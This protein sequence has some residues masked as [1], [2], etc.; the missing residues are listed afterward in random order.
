[1]K[2][3]EIASRNYKRFCSLNGSNY[4]ASEFALETIL[5]IIDK[6]NLSHILELGLGIGSISDTV[7]KYSK[8]KKQPIEYLGTEKNDF[9]LGVLPN[10]V[11]DYDKIQIFS[12][13]KEIHDKKF[14]LII[15]DGSDDLL[16]S[17]EKY[18][19]KNALIFIEGGRAE[20]TKTVLDIF[21]KSLFVNVITLKKNPPYAHEGRSVDSYIGGG[22]LIFTNPTFKMKL[23][24]MKE[25]ISTFIKIKI[26]K[27]LKK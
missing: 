2:E 7:L 23:F 5:R 1:M 8:I 4:I 6:F 27:Y 12:E 18:C 21:P 15:I 13:I 25:K 3:Y 26:R 24:W 20:Q 11:E 19:T 16:K 9:C 17:I 10:Y 22:Q 14:D